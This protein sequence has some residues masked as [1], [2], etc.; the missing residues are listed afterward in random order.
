MSEVRVQ[1]Q[2]MLGSEAKV[3]LGSVITAGS[4][5]WVSCYRMETGQ[6]WDQRS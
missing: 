3:T 4:E 1:G 6:G 5:V 2:E